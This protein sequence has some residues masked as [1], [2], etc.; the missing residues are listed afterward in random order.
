MT[1]CELCGAEMSCHGPDES[2]YGC[3]M[4]FVSPL[5]ISIYKG[6]LVNADKGEPTMVFDKV[7]ATTKQGRPTVLCCSCLS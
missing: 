3:G 5:P 7:G 2:G 6:L 4:R 1:T